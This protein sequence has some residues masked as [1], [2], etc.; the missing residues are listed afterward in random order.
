MF[1]STSRP[2]SL[3]DAWRCAHRLRPS[4]KRSYAWSVRKTRR[5]DRKPP[6]SS[7]GHPGRRKTVRSPNVS[8]RSPTWIAAVTAMHHAIVNAMRFEIRSSTR[9]LNVVYR[10]THQL[11]RWRLESC[12]TGMPSSDVSSPRIVSASNHPRVSVCV[13]LRSSPNSPRSTTV[14][15]SGGANFSIFCIRCFAS[16]SASLSDIFLGMGPG[17]RPSELRSFSWHRRGN[18]AAAPRRRSPKSGALR[19]QCPACAWREIVPHT[20]GGGEKAAAI[21]KTAMARIVAGSQT[22]PPALRQ[23][24]GEAF[25]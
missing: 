23:R 6:T 16:S 22:A 21:C 1:V 15:F 12:E 13:D 10:S 7:C 2:R 20:T 11:V 14:Y 17:S 4:Q 5:I 8:V 3:Q 18:T 19:A 9:E 25:A 24:R